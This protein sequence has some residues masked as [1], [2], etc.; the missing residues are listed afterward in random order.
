MRSYVHD[1]AIFFPLSL[2]GFHTEATQAQGQAKH[3]HF[4]SLW[5]L[6]YHLCDGL[7]LSDTALAFFRFCRILYTCVAGNKPSLDLAN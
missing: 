2:H 7:H 5:R 3:K 6:F 1:L 4:N